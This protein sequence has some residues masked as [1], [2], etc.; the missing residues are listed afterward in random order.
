MKLCIGYLLLISL[1]IGATP[2]SASIVLATGST[3][4]YTFVNPTGD[5]SW[6][7]TTG[8]WT[9]GLAPFGN[10][11]GGYS[12]DPSGNFDYNTLWAADGSDGDDLW[13]RTAVDF[14]GF[15]LSTAKW[16]LGVDNGFKLYLNG[17]LIASGNGEGYTWQ[18]EYSGNFSTY[19]IPGVNI[20]AVALEDH[21]G[22]TAFDMQITA[23]AIPEPTTIIIW[24]LLGGL[25]LVFAW[26]KRKAA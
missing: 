12:S 16:N 9:T 24:S 26:R 13:V 3:W 14:T 19:V 20:V 1:V 7:N 18:W 25:G 23:T 21:G 11:L 2:A 10:N 4:E 6:N 15:D 5:S 17:F 22:L 8:G